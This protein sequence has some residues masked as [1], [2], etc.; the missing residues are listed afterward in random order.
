MIPDELFEQILSDMWDNFAIFSH[1]NFL[2]SGRGVIA[3]NL[4]SSA[5]TL[6]EL[7]VMY[8][9]YDYKAGEP[10]ADIAKMLRNYNPKQEM[11]IQF[12]QPTG[13]VRTVRAKAPNQES[14]PEQLWLE[15]SAFGG[16][17]REEA[18]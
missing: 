15:Q 13:Q 4:P 8:A 5:N 11:I 12:L 17:F 3:L 6:D 16:A 1:E 14:A 10:E 7:E 2:T 9:V 18:N